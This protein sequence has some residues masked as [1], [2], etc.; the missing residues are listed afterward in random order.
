MQP[1]ALKL[2]VATLQADLARKICTE[3]THRPALKR[4]V[5]EG[6]PGL[7]A[8]NE[9]KRV[10]CGA[11]DF[12][13]TAKDIP[14]G[15]MESKDVNCD[16]E[17]SENSEQLR[18]Y[19]SS[20]GNLIL[21]DYVEFRWYVNGERRSV[22][23]LG[24]VRDN[25][26][27]L[28]M[29]GAHQVGTLLEDFTS[30]RTTTINDPRQLAIRMA[31][32]AKH[33]RHSVAVAFETEDR[34]G[35]STLHS[36]FDAFRTVLLGE[37]TPKQ[38]ADMY[39]QTICYGMFAARCSPT[40]SRPF[41]R[42][43][44][45]YD[46]PRT[47][48]FLQ[49]LF[50]Q[51]AGPDL[52]PGIQWIVD[53]L[54]H[55]LERADM[56]S[57]LDRFGKRTQ[58]EDP[59]IHFY[60]TFLAEYDPAMREK[61]GVY[62]T[63]EPVVSYI[64]QSIDKILQRD[65]GL[66]NGL[67]DRSE[68][69]LPTPARKRISGADCVHRVQILDPAAGTGTFLHSIVSLIHNRFAG[70]E[71]KWS[72]YVS[73]HLLPR[74]YGFELLM[75]PYAVAHMKLGLLLQQTEYNFKASERIR[76]YLTNTLEEAHESPNLPLFARWLAEE[77][78]A[79][80]SVK[81]DAPVM[82]I[83]GN[84]P[85]S[86]H[87]SNKGPWIS[88][89]LADYKKNC[90][91]LKKPAQAKA[92]SDDY[93][94][95]TRFAQ[96]RIEKTGYGILAFVMNHGF[97][98][99]PTFR[100]MR[101]SLLEAFDDVYILNLHG[102]PTKESA[103]DGG[104]DENVFD[105]LQGVAIAVFVRRQ[106]RRSENIVRYCDLWGERGDAD[107]EHPTGKYGWLVSHDVSNT[108]WTVIAPS[109]PQR[110]LV[111]TNSER[112]V[113]YEQGWSVP[114]I[115][116]PNGRAAPGILTTHDAF[117]ISW[118]KEEA[119]A[120]VERLLATKSEEEA[121]TLFKLC[122][123][124]QWKY[125][126]AIEELS[127]GSWRDEALPVLYRPFDRRWTIFNRNVAVHRRERVT[128][129][130]ADRKNVVLVTSRLTK[131]ESFRHVLV[132]D[133]VPEIICLSPKTSNNAFVF[134]LYLHDPGS[135]LPVS[136][137]N[138][139]R[140]FLN[141]FAQASGLEYSDNVGRGDLRTNCGP[142]DLLAYVVAVLHSD[143]YRSR[144]QEYLSRDFPRIPLFGDQQIIQKLCRSGRELIDAFLGARYSK[145][146]QIRFPKPGTNVVGRV[147]YKDGRIMLNETQYLDGVPEAAW[148]YRIGGYQICEKWLKNRKGRELVFEDLEEFS[149]IVRSIVAIQ[150]S[151][152]DVDRAIAERNGWA[153]WAAS[154]TDKAAVRPSGSVRKAPAPER[155]PPVR[156][157]PS[158][159]RHQ[160]P[161]AMIA[162]RSR[163]PSLRPRRR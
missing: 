112:L 100:G 85:Y 84:P 92:L 156:A 37:L 148:N 123:Q 134:P 136:R 38:F 83:C 5:E 11:P 157:Q 155:V 127:D 120:K 18:R 13:V 119:I 34:D 108:E 58:N 78:S 41:T 118:S 22:A 73:Q 14:V 45:A 135:A 7:I 144:Y 159:V 69:R 138:I 77:A 163:R 145:S 72:G 43:R 105:I 150:A 125:R 95:F 49:K 63:P 113:E 21:T 24:S 89:L 32:I 102:N 70:D 158:G 128:G 62:Y 110:L 80:G 147:A 3:N 162:D 48:P 25:K 99:N 28:D 161:M 74:V 33:I 76:L 94:K 149:G 133:L 53:D 146:V 103:P 75:A 66:A 42:Y 46:L 2:Y 40:V 1:R 91:E 88:E 52:H 27:R 64:V 55:L 124:D 57:I 86:R 87:S 109:E 36:Q 139:A 8:T 154:A 114:D 35:E 4:L 71:G 130:I 117:A 60:E 67:A 142:E 106:Q 140:G 122:T 19:L 153:A 126:R 30:D 54:A 152:D 16:L 115:F 132:T 44:A 151:C 79:A 31:M 98:D 104:P 59:V 47:N 12:V 56:R 96:W 93:V 68:V 9:P 61:R 23:R 26:L 101:R 81:E 129:Q 111:P 29:D 51:L 65:F 116:A 50:G 39:A 131:G 121:R 6:F 137:I 82:V 107:P 15:Y 143:E 20:L 90:P 160:R 97:L 10:A 141:A 17:R